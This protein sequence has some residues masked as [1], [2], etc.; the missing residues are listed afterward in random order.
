MLGYS[1]LVANQWNPRGRADAAWMNNP[2]GT[3]KKQ[4]K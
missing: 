2:D 3:E 1:I 4:K